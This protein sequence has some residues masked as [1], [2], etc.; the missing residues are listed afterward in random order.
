MHFQ[1]KMYRGKWAAV[2]YD[3]SQTRRYS[4]G[5]TDREEAERALASFKV[6][7]SQPEAL[8]VAWLWEAYEKA[9][10]GKA[11]LDTMHHTWKALSPVFGH[12]L[13]DTITQEICENYTEKRREDN[14]S[15]GTI[16][17]ELG[18]LR[19]V[20]NWAVKR[21]YLTIAPHITLPR[22]PEPKERHLTKE[23]ARRLLDG[24]TKP[25]IRLAILL[26]LGTAARVTA[27]LQLKWERVDFETGLIRL[28]DPMEKVRRK[29][30]AVVPM[31]NSVRAA[32]SSAHKAAITEFVI[33]WGEGP[34]KSV[35]KGLATASKNAGL[36]T[37]TAHVLRHTA[38]VWM[39]E[40][41]HPMSE[42]AQY[43]GHRDSRTTER[44]YARYSPDYLRAAAD[45]LDIGL[46]DASGSIE[47]K[48]TSNTANLKIVTN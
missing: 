26:L 44:I 13:P 10:K 1:L 2:W 45:S 4:F 33:E 27:L 18:H 5:T 6:T 28:A 40:A 8:T 15:D 47:P 38:A 7:V 21:K 48:G 24:A 23:Q 12:L 9:N 31:N 16:W 42:I 39:A 32:L 22:K 17:T 20:M 43:L 14:K 19:T 37:V 25:H 34:V 30:R 11:V 29:G 3:G 35:K 41:G 36:E 46:Y